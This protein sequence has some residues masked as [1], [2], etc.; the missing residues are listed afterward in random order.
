MLF[1]PRAQPPAAQHPSSTYQPQPAG[2]GLPR[3]DPSA[4]ATMVMPG[5][6]PSRPVVRVDAVLRVRSRVVRVGRGVLPRT[7]PRVS[8]MALRLP[9]PAWVAG[10][11]RKWLR[12][13]LLAGITI[14]AYLVPQVMA[15]AE[16]AGLPPV[17]GLW[18]A[19]GAL[20]AYALLGSSPQLSV[21]PESTTALMTGAALGSLSLAT[22]Q[23]YADFASALAVMVACL[24]VLGWIG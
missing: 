23:R 3:A 10:Y 9:R 2:P 19:V 8:P 1:V 5:I 15:Y 16:V 21:G 18:A 20:V 12:G 4:A 24:C 11:Q 22:P 7:R 13:D 17:V 6:L 14:T